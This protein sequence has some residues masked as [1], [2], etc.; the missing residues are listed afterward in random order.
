MKARITALLLAGS[1]CFSLAACGGAS[2][3]TAPASSADEDAGNEEDYQIE[4]PEA[5]ANISEEDDQALTG[6]LTE[7][8]Y[9]NPYFG[10]RFNKPEG[11]TI[12]SLMDD[13]KDLMPFAQTYAEGLGGKN[14]LIWTADEDA[15]MGP[16]IYAVSEKDR[17]K[18]EEDLVRER[19]DF[20]TK[21]NESAGVDSAIS[22][23]TLSI[24]GEEHP[25]C[26]EKYNYE[27]KDRIYSTVYILKGDF[28][29]DISFYASPETFD[30]MTGLI[31]KIE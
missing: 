30:A 31:E 7:D 8:A 4:I 18:T 24:A 20:E 23:E 6:T 25:A 3:Q 22:V 29:C 26:V 1:I 28:E 27:G 16:S 17:G 14:I 9:I 19:A 15:N 10:L 5:V 11:G 13:G 2:L 21:L 12:E